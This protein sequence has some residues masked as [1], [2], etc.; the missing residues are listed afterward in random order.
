MYLKY[1]TLFNIGPHKEIHFGTEKNPLPRGTIG[2]FGPNGCGKTT[3]TEAIV[4]AMTNRWTGIADTKKKVIRDKAKEKDKAYVDI[5]FQHAEQ[6]VHL[7]NSIRPDKITITGADG[8]YVEGWDGVKARM[9]SLGISSDVLNAVFLRQN[10]IDALFSATSTD[11]AT[12][13]QKMLMLGD[14]ALAKKTLGIFAGFKKTQLTVQDK[15]GEINA[16]IER[17]R[18]ERVEIETQRDAILVQCLTNEEYEVL[19]DSVALVAQ[20][21]SI[22]ADIKKI[23]KRGKESREKIET[24]KKVL[25]GE[26]QWRVDL[27]ATKKYVAVAAAD[28]QAI[29]QYAI[30]IAKYAEYKAKK[31]KID[32]DESKLKTIVIKPFD[33]EEW[34]KITTDGKVLA[35]KR[36]ELH[37]WIESMAKFKGKSKCPTCN[38][39]IDD[40]QKMITDKSKQRDTYDAQLLDLRAKAKD[41]KAKKEAF[42]A[43]TTEKANLTSKIAGAKATLGKAV[44]QPELTEKAERIKRIEQARI[45]I[46]KRNATVKLLRAARA[47]YRAA[48]PSLKEQI[49]TY[50]ARRA[51]LTEIDKPGEDRSADLEAQDRLRAKASELKGKIKQVKESVERQQ[52]ELA[53]NAKKIEDSLVML[54]RIDVIEKASELLHPTRMPLRVSRACLKELEPAINRN[55]KRFGGGFSCRPTDDLDLMISMPDRS[56]RSISRLSIG[57]RVVLSICFWLAQLELFAGDIGMLVLDEPTAN[58]DERNRRYLG[59]VLKAVSRSLRN[60]LQMIVITHDPLLKPSFDRIIEIG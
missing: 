7:L 36:D 19:R 41:L 44:E 3:L 51:T 14:L 24:A 38:Q 40:I 25:T 47:D 15:S 60:R 45:K 53:S 10:A 5:T 23:A 55:I 58:L 20:R 16:E 49:T 21:N 57:Q 50:R 43:A 27:A 54:Q 30:D 46:R 48:V 12:V 13:Y 8:K 2:I 9:E 11:R 18:A 52:A 28:L 32:A 31:N 35:G 34:L 4:S 56:E 17:L 6:Q 22:I 39:A 37:A 29:R 26:A 42:D 33:Q 59:E 1:A